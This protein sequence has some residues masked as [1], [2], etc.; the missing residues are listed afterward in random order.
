M[1]HHLDPEIDCV[2]Y[3]G[4]IPD[5]NRELQKARELD[6]PA[7]T[8]FQALGEMSRDYRVIAIESSR[9]NHHHRHAHPHFGS[10]R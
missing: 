10:R 4:A 1:V 5:T 8:Y 7:L 6:I 9:Q 2:I 3:N